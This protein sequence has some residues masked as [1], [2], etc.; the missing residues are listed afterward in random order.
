[1][2]TA[3][4]SHFVEINFGIAI[5]STRTNFWTYLALMVVVGHIFPKISLGENSGRPNEQ[6]NEI[7]FSDPQNTANA[8]KKR[9]SRTTLSSTSSDWI[10]RNQEAI[11]LGLLVGIVMTTLVFDFVSN[12]RGL[13]SPLPI[14]WQ[15]LT[16]LPLQ[17]YSFS[18]G[19]LLMVLTSWFFMG[20]V[21]SA[22]TKTLKIRSW[23]KGFALVLGVS[24]S[25]GLFYAI[26]QAGA[27]ATIS[28]NSATTMEQVMDQVMRF[29]GILS[30]FYISIFVSLLALAFVLPGS[31]PTRTSPSKAPG[32]IMAILM[33]FSVC[34]IAFY[35]NVRVIQ[36]DIV[37]KIADPFTRSGQWPVA[38]DIYRRAN[39]LAPNEDYYYLFLGRAY[40]EHAKTLKDTNEID[41]FVQEAEFDLLKAQ[42]LNPLN[43]DH[44]ANLARLYSTWA[45][46]ATDPAL[47]SKRAEISSDYFSKSLKMSRNS[48]VLW[49]EWAYLMLTMLDEPE[50][51][52]KKISRAIEIDPQYHRNYALLGEYYLRK[53]L[54]VADINSR[55]EDFQEAIKNL[56][57]ALELP[58]QFEPTAKF[59]YAQM[60]AGVYGQSGQFLDA[61]QAYQLAIQLAPKGTGVW[62]LYETIAALYAKIGD[63]GNA[64]TNL[65]SALNTAP[66]DQKERLRGLI[67]SLQP[68]PQPE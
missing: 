38:I 48:A 2:V 63:D 25:L 62:Q 37:Y 31:I 13:K 43:T 60:L 61:V 14:I 15:A 9:R 22:E 29:E 3:I 39:A 17:N 28:R 23:W 6:G 53:G 16:L 35:T 10:G 36:S 44:T 4:L 66:D 34:T 65:Q 51:A 24:L 64:L 47:R 27:L 54:A 56:N 41:R 18:Y 67:G 59:N 8:R 20:V 45:T 46:Y 49:D 68:T 5:A 50:E 12:P 52:Y 21:W 32:I 30:R 40:L 58:A 11:A 1:L 55:N 26:S 42:S 7:A 33:F 57:K 19:I